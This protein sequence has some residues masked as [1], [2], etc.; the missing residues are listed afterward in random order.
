VPI[1]NGNHYEG[2]YTLLQ[3]KDG[4]YGSPIGYWPSSSELTILS[5]Y[6][7]TGWYT[8][9][10]NGD[11][12]QRFER[13]ENSG[14]AVFSSSGNLTLYARFE[15]IG[16]MTARSPWSITL[17]PRGLFEHPIPSR[18]IPNN[19]YNYLQS[20]TSRRLQRIRQILLH[21]LNAAKTNVSS[22]TTFW[23]IRRLVH[24]FAHQVYYT[25]NQY[26]FPFITVH[27]D[28]EKRRAYL[29]A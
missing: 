28:S 20:Y 13:F 18:T 16:N 4:P 17:R 24:N 26:R 11:E 29:T 22:G 12:V 9:K 19:K 1:V 5:G 15:D 21:E 27:A 3:T 14:N 25:L 8:K 7:F 10:T 2:A 23:S 6:V